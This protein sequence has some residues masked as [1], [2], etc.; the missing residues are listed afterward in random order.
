MSTGYEA[1]I[2]SMVNPLKLRTS[3]YGL[4]KSCNDWHGTIDTFLVATMLSAD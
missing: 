1:T 2:W 3:S 4:K